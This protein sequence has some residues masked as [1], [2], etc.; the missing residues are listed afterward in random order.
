MREAAEKFAEVGELSESLGNS[1]KTLKDASDG[2][3]EFGDN[4]RRASGEQVK[5]ATASEKAAASNERV[6][7]K[8]SPLPGSIVGIADA[9]GEAGKSVKDGA[10][11]AK[12]CYE[13]ANEFQQSWFKGVRVGMEAMRARLE[14][15]IKVYGEKVE[16]QT[17]AHFERWAQEL[18]E[19]YGKFSAVAQAV[20]GA[21]NDLIDS[22]SNSNEAGDGNDLAA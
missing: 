18:E 8:L 15:L 22:I 13:A 9:L 6:A 1:A 7:E 20:E 14:E 12:G 2:L 17:Q 5:A 10:N 16:G 21:A 4:V 3:N 11:E 19:S